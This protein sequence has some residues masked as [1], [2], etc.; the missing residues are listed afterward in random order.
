MSG[1]ES[2]QKLVGEWEGRNDLYLM[3]GD[4]VRESDSA[5]SVTLVAKGGFV[6]IEYT[7]AYE[8]DPQEGLLLIGPADDDNGAK[9]V[10]VDS[11]HTGGRIMSSEGTFQDAGSVS[12][13]TTYPAPS[14]PDWGWRTIIEPDDGSSFKIL[15]YN[16]MPEGEE[17]LAVEAA[18]SR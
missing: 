16:V 15:M 8:G 2:L 3:P 5:A 1:I 13:H 14:G 6:K 10:W 12:V 18:Y 7:W 17:M 4:P 11:F 9:I